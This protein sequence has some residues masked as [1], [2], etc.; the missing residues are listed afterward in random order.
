METNT[1]VQ[2]TLEDIHFKYLNLESRPDRNQQ[3]QV[4]LKKFG[5]Q[6]ERVQASV[7][8]DSMGGLVLSS[9]ASPAQK[10]CFLSHYKMIESYDGEKI[11]GIFEDDVVLCGD[12]MERMQYIAEHMTL[13]WDIFFLSAFFHGEAHWHD[14][15]YT[16]TSIPHIVRTYGSFCTHAYLVNP[17]SKDKILSLLRDNAHKSYAVDHCLILI[18][19]EIL[20]YS[21]VPGI[22]T[23]RPGP[24]D[25]GHNP[26]KEQTE[27][28]KGVCG[29]HVFAEKLADFSW[30]AFAASAKMGQLRRHTFACDWGQY[31]LFF[32]SY[33]SSQ[34]KFGSCVQE[35]SDYKKIRQYMESFEKGSVFI[36]V[37]ANS[38]LCAIPI[39]MRGYKVCAFEPV[40]INAIAL[41]QAI[42]LNRASSVRLFNFA[43]S[44]VEEKKPIYVPTA[45]D[46]AS[47]NSVA[48]VKNVPK[49]GMTSELV[50]CHTFDNVLA[51]FSNEIDERKIRFIK[52]DTQGFEY[53]VLLG[54]SRFLRRAKQ[55]SILV[56]VDDH[57]TLAGYSYIDLHNFLTDLGFK[58]KPWG[59]YDKL[60]TK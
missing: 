15:E 12:F 42:S 36:D 26:N 37:G 9:K 38:G 52:I 56:E 4:E 16:L 49:D 35:L 17:K 39:S 22:A 51:C 31:T 1:T 24:T 19:P 29:P 32:P 7:P 58:E 47:F 46:N 50:S 5:I 2:I 53:P 8:G 27:Y 23:Q 28:F 40:E 55:L 11:L 34:Y 45:T 57:S 25:I 59:R 6:A 3:V 54:M 33:F 44:D 60:F 20:A 30:D 21:F 48:A 13:E 10:A 41:T 14:R 18:Q 43:L